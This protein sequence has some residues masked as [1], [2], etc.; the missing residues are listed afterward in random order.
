MQ[1]TPSIMRS[2][3]GNVKVFPEFIAFRDKLFS[4]QS[5]TQVV[6]K[7]LVT[8]YSVS[9]SRRAEANIT[10]RPYASL[11]ICSAGSRHTPY[12]QL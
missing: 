5:N 7:Y 12:I 1:L 3:T 4:L 10:D 8:T 6:H 9:F 2:H 11:K